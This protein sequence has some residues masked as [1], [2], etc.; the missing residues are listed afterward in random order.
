MKLLR[1]R[2]FAQSIVCWTSYKIVQ[3]LL[4]V[5][6]WGQMLYIDNEGKLSQKLQ[7]L[8]KFGV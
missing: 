5:S 8:L 6:F 2:N 1:D 3:T 4:L 7:S